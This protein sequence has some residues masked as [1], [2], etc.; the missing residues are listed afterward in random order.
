LACCQPPAAGYTRLTDLVRKGEPRRGLRGITLLRTAR[1]VVL[2]VVASALL[3]SGAIAQER[4]GDPGK[5]STYWKQ[6]MPVFTH[7]RCINCHGATEPVSGNNHGGGPLVEDPEFAC[8]GCHTANTVVVPGRCEFTPSVGNGAVTRPDGTV[9]FGSCAPGEKSGEARVP[10]GPTW[11]QGFP[12]DFIDKDAR[13]LCLGVK[14]RMGPKKLLE[15][16]RNDELIGFAFEGKRAIDATSPFG[17]VEA[18]PPPL[19]RDAFVALINLWITEAAMSCGIDGTVALDDNV[20]LDKA[21]AFGKITVRNEITAKIDIKKDVASSD[22]HYDEASAGA[23]ATMAP[24]CPAKESA[25]IHFKA[26]GKPDARYEINILPG[27][28]YRMRFTL[29]A[30]EGETV[31][32]YKEDICRPGFRGREKL[33]TE[34][35]IPLRFGVEGQV[36]HENE[37]HEFILKGSA[38]VPDNFGAAGVISSGNRKVTWDIVVK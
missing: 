32:S 4:I 14:S 31:W 29:G 10:A 16:V 28:T 23:I 6:M 35:T 8:I 27:N 21:S 7:P 5:W 1:S 34:S 15:H 36:L 13:E 33:P 3:A 12:P 9:T 17:P 22:L 20:K 37:E 2:A 25:E 11:F 30:I 26:D 19:S 38:T 24:G 18:E